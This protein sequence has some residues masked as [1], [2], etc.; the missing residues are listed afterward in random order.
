LGIDGWKIIVED[1]ARTLNA[2]DMV[3]IVDRERFMV[4][5]KE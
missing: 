3:L 5:P 4:I 1:L 2:N